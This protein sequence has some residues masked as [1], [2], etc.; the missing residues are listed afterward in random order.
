MTVIFD[1]EALLAF[2]FNEQGAGE[3]KRWLDYVYDGEL[4]GYIS[5]INLAELR[6]IAARKTSPGQADSHV[7][8]LRDMG[9]AEYSIDGLWKAASELKATHNPSIGD[10]Y[11]VAAADD[12]DND[13]GR[14]VTLLVG[15]DDDYD[16][17]ADNERFKHLIER[18]R[19]EPA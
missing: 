2:S 15:A 13:D 18:F 11:A 16:V 6:Y 1:A 10:A 8:A 5:T 19:E 17:F 12:L 7:R 9:V 4:D 14:D 3:V